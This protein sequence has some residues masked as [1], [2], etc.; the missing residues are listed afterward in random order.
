MF[1]VAQADNV[2]YDINLSKPFATRKEA[3]DHLAYVYDN[4]VSTYDKDELVDA[5]TKC[6]KKKFVVT[7]VGDDIYYGSVKEIK[8]EM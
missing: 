1:V 6:G 3:E 4:L 2:S 5:N 8:E 7:T